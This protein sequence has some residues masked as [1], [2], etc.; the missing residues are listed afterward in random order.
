MSWFALFR[1]LT[2]KG[3]IFVDL[4]DTMFSVNIDYGN[5]ENFIYGNAQGVIICPDLDAGLIILCGRR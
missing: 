2:A 1:L 4:V 3:K 5:L